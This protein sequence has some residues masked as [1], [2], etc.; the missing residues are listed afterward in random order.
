MTGRNQSNIIKPLKHI[1]NTCLLFV[2]ALIQL[3][4]MY[5]IFMIPFI[6]EILGFSAMAFTKHL[7]LLF[8]F[9]MIRYTYKEN[10]PTIYNS[11]EIEFSFYFITF[12]SFF[13]DEYFEKHPLN[14]EGKNIENFLVIYPIFLVTFHIKILLLLLNIGAMNNINIKHFINLVSSVSVISIAETVLKPIISNTKQLLMPRIFIYLS[15]FTLSS[16][17]L[18]RY[19]SIF[20][21]TLFLI[22]Y[23]SLIFTLDS[24]LFNHV[25]SNLSYLFDNN[26]YCTN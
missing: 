22:F 4:S 26:E 21:A 2:L 10:I 18:Y 14:F 9:L 12:I 15:E 23:I 6:T 3:I 19:I 20:Q 5:L 7:T 11:Y 8:I 17:I 13:I 25:A 16:F 24:N 1:K